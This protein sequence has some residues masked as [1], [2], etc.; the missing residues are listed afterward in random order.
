MKYSAWFGALGL[1]SLACFAACGDDDDMTTT[2]PPTGGGGE[3]GGADASVSAGESNAPGEA[4]SGTGGAGTELA[5]GPEDG[6]CI[7]RND[8]FGDEALWTD[9]LRL[10]EVVQTL[11]PKAAL[12]LGLKVDAD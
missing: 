10:H 7:F 3:G 4:G 1:V 8:T 11:S 2:P 12:G 9:T 5:C 6:Q